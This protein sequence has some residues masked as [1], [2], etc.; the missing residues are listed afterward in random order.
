MSTSIIEKPASR[1]VYRVLL[2]MGE[3]DELEC[4]F[5]ARPFGGG[6]RKSVISGRKLRESMDRSGR[7]TGAGSYGIEIDLTLL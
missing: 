4:T 2:I 1:R 6:P 5:H 3:P 7:L